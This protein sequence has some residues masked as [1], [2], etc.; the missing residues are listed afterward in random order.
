MAVLQLPTTLM[1]PQAQACR[2]ELVQAIAASQDRVL[3]LD[4]SP[5]A[6]FDSS[7]L[8]VL[9]ACRRE[10]S[11]QGRSLQV[12]GLPQRLREL[13]RLYGVHDWLMPSGS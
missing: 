13:A 9:L 10:A 7:A 6:Q 3:L 11:Q 4:A 8:A 1:H 2:R 5:L 12:Q